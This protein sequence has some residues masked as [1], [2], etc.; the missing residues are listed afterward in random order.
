MRTVRTVAELRAVLAPARRE[1]LTIGLVPTMGAL[2]EGH[3]S[4]IR[5]AR[6]QCDVVVVSLFVNPAQFN[7][8]ADLE[9]Y[10]RREQRRRRARRSRRRGRA[11]RAR[12][13]RRSTRRASPR[14]SRCSALTERLEGAARGAEHFRGVTT[15]V[16]KLLCMALPDVAYFGQKDAQQAGGHPPRWRAT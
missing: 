1:G 6:A 14:A 5:R 11:V 13:S 7:E 3:L 10:P 8:R 2:H 4:L 15:V 12:R 9:R 16:T